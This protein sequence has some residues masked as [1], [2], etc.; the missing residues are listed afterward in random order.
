LNKLYRETRQPRLKSKIE[1][2]IAP[3]NLSCKAVVSP[4]GKD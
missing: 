2:V 1:D 3:W 4:V